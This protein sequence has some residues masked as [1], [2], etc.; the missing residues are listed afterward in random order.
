MTHAPEVLR[1]LADKVDPAHTAVLSIDMVNDFIDPRGKTALRAQRPLDHAQAVIEPL[2]RLLAEA[3]TAGV[4]VV[5]IQ[6]TTMP[7]GSSTSGPWLDARSRAT[8]SVEDVCLDG[9][10]GQQVI[11][12]LAPKPGDLQVKKF[13]YSGFAG[14]R[15]DALLRSRGIRTVVCTGVSTNVCVEATAREAFSHEYYVVY[16]QDACGSWSPELHAAT[17][18]S[19]GHRYATV[20]H[21][22]ELS[23]IWT[24]GVS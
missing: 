19:A 11:D 1:T 22:A 7:D 8:Y 21:V 2:A 17:I 16:A 14:T 4:L 6:H 23:E 5:H 13:R 15:L 3:R 20:C 10:W 9:S 24:K 18:A 12:A